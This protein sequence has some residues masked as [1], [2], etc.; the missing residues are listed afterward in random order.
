MDVSVETLDTHE[1]RIT[2]TVPEDV[3]A[4]TRRDL[5]RK[6]SKQIRIPGFRPGNAPLNVIIGAIGEQTFM[7]ELADELGSKFYAE[8]IEQAKIDPYGPG[9]LEDIKPSPMQLIVKVPLE[10]T[11]DLKDYTSV[12]VPF[13]APTVSEEDVE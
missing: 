1:A 3:V 4:Q 5:A 10:P 2:I 7:S 9:Q 6:L 13:T 8:A 12:R 11:V